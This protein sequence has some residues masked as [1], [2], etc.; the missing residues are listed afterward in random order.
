MNLARY[1]CLTLLLAC[2]GHSSGTT[3]SGS[4]SINGTV[5]GQALAT[6]DTIGVSGTTTDNGPVQPVAG[7]IITNVGNVCGILQ[8]DGNPASSEVL[9]VRVVGAS[10]VVGVGKYMLNGAGGVGGAVSLLVQDQSCNPTVQ[11]TATQGSITL[12]TVSSS[13][14]AGSFDV[15][16]PTGDHVTG[17]FSGPICT[18]STSGDAATPTC[19]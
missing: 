9:Y 13:T 2:G 16:F 4:A 14:I 5:S 6:S 12:T 19:Q 18:F 17:T 3:G 1:S 10:G 8:H 7:A 15:T 11:S